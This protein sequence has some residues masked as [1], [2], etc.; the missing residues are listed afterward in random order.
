MENV[1]LHK[2]QIKIEERSISESELKQADEIWLTSSTKEIMAVTHLN[3]I[4]VAE[5]KPGASW[6]KMMSLYQQYKETL[7]HSPESSQE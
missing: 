6:R 7:R 2:N 5:G 3:D 1:P 4:A